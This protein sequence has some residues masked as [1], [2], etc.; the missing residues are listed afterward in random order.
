[1]Y[2]K[3]LLRSAFDSQFCNRRCG[4]KGMFSEASMLNLLLRYVV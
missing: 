2:I 3:Q 1:M 4:E